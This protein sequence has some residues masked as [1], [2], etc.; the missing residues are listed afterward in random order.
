MYRVTLN[1]KEAFDN[2]IHENFALQ[3]QAN[4]EFQHLVALRIS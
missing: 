4:L 3:I 2:E 1:L